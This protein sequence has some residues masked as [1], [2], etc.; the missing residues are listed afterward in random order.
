MNSSTEKRGVKATATSLRLIEAVQDGDGMTVSE[1]A[2]DLNLAKSTVKY[3]LVTLVQSEYLVRENDRYYLGLQFFELG[4]DALSRNMSEATKKK[5]EELAVRTNG[6]A[7]FSVEEYGRI[8]LLYDHIGSSA[9]PGFQ[10]GSHHHM[11]NNAAGKAILSHWSEDRV[12]ELIDRR[13]LPTRTDS[14]IG[15][16]RELFDALERIREQGYAIND[17]EYMEGHRSIS[18]VVTNPDGSIH[19]ALSVG[20]PSY[21]VSAE[22][23]ES[24]FRSP[25]VQASRELEEELISTDP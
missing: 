16:R 24:E 21:R 14:T 13:G 7:D 23:L 18:V 10:E 20:G 11:H 1:L 3:H 5:V 12:N 22:M 4:Q 8:V 6:E 9:E 2:F 17:E 19:G 25:L 15:T